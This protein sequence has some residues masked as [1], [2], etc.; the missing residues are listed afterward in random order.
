[1]LLLY[2]KSKNAVAVTFSLRVLPNVGRPSACNDAAFA[3]RP[4][5]HWCQAMKQ[6]IS[7]MNLQNRYREFSQWSFLW[8]NRIGAENAVTVGRFN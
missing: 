5:K 4:A 6:R 2:H 7:L 1:M 3:E 8:R